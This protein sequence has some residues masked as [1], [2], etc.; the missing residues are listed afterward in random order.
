MR[1]NTTRIQIDHVNFAAGMKSAN[2][3]TNVRG[4]LRAVETVR[5]LEPRQL[6][7]LVFEVLVEIVLPIEDAV[8]VWARKPGFVLYR[9][10]PGYIL[11]E[12]RLVEGKDLVCKQ[13]RG[14]QDATNSQYVMHS[15]PTDD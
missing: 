15:H 10:Q 7:A 2:V 1:L 6:A 8:A 5:T 4:F 3:S 14:V 13:K 9:I 11:T 12:E